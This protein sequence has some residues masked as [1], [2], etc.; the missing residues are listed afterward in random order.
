MI[1]DGIPWWKI[2]L[3][4]KFVKKEIVEMIYRTDEE[5]KEHK[6]GEIMNIDKII[7]KEVSIDH[8]NIVLNLI[9]EEMKPINKET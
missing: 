6:Y 9:I 2:E 8:L 1:C 3:E 7:D 4:N 5:N